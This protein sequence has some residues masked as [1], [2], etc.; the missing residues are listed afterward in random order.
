MTMQS[1]VE[2]KPDEFGFTGRECPECKGYFKIQFGTGLTGEGLKCH[3]PY[4]GHVGEPDDFFTE[5]QIEYANS[6]AVRKFSGALHKELKKSEFNYKPK[7][8]FD[9]GISMKVGRGRLPPIRHY[10]ERTLETEVVCDNCTLRYAVYGV[11]AFCPD[12][13]QHNS[14]QTL[15]KNL[16]VVEKM[17]DLANKVEADI[18]NKLV[19][20]GLENCVS[21]LDGFGRELCRIHANKATNPGKVG[22]VSFQRLEDAKTKILHIFEH[23]LS[24]HTTA[25]EWHVANLN[26]HKRHVI[27]HKMG[28]A[29]REYISKTKDP[30]AILDRKVAIT[31]EDVRFT[32]AVVRKIAHGFFDGITTGNR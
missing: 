2:I 4:C 30:K 12:C 31:A 17:L 19:E 28:V 8:E 24:T 26:F 1:S 29:D 14:L 13:G 9:L 15:D 27:A 18:A 5:A 23:D 22:R 11:F 21:I 16:E 32:V 10:K 6:V 25:D 3:C 20:D 7:G